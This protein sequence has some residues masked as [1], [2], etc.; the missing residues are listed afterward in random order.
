VN[1][2]ARGLRRWWGAL[3]LAGLNVG[4]AARA[5]GPAPPGAPTALESCGGSG[6]ERLEIVVAAPRDALAPDTSATLELRRAIC[7][8]FRDDRWHVRFSSGTPERRGGA[9][10]RIVLELTA[11][12]ARMQADGLRG[13]WT[14]DV[15]LVA[16]LDE[17]GVEA[18]AEALHS[19]VQAELAPPIV[20]RPS[21]LRSSAA[22][23]TTLA[24]PA[25]AAPPPLEP[26]PVT[27][28]GERRAAQRPHVEGHHLP[29]HTALGYQLYARGPEPSMHG[30]ALHIEV[31]ALPWAVTLG[32]YFRASLFTSAT[33]RVTG[34]DVRS[35]GASLS[36]GAAASAPV[37]GLTLRAALGGGLDLVAVAARV[38]DPELVRL[39]PARD[40]SPRPFIGAEAGVRYRAGAF[41][42]ALDALLRMLAFDSQY[43]LLTP[44]GPVALLQPWQVQPGALL[45]LG[46]VW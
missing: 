25:D 32:A 1:S 28:V 42:I 27:A 11:A 18:V 35:S 31:D 34:F 23:R 9:S 29:V 41:E 46:Y 10:L 44:N 43:Q 8:W 2:A 13:R 4:T 36:L 5:A 12:A 16:G 22:P 19:A 20:A 7:D 24:T 17:T 40:T 39:L 45:E 14:H 37:A 15:P 33:R 26:A 21:A 38:N 3:L 30:P 6:P